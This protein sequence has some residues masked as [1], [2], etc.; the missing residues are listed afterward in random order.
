MERKVAA[1]CAHVR[2]G[3]L[4]SSSN[5]MYVLRGERRHAGNKHR[6]QRQ[7][8]AVGDVVGPRERARLFELSSSVTLRDLR[9][10][11]ERRDKDK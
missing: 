2:G 7:A 8:V 11:K 3:T 6:T 4:S 1:P 10:A 9:A 5:N